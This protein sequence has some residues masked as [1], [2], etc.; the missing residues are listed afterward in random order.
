MK[1]S[2]SVRSW[3]VLG[4]L[5]L[6]LACENR[7][8]APPAP[9][10]LPSA[11]VSVA[12]EPPG[13]TLESLPIS[14]GP[15]DPGLFGFRRTDLPTVTTY[16]H[17]RAR[18]GRPPPAAFTI[19]WGY[20]KR[21]KPVAGGLLVD[22][23]GGVWN[24]TGVD[25]EREYQ[26]LGRVPSTEVVGMLA[27]AR[28][29]AKTTF[30]TSPGCRDC[31]GKS[32]RAY[33]IAGTEELTLA[34]EGLTEGYLKSPDADAVILW[35]LAIQERN[36]AR[37]ALGP[38]GL[39]L[40]IVSELRSLPITA[41]TPGPLLLELEHFHVGA[42]WGVAVDETGNVFRFNARGL[43]PREFRRI[44]KVARA[45][46]RRLVRLGQRAETSEWQDVRGNQISSQVR[47]DGALISDLS[48]FG[49]RRIG[50]EADELIAWIYAVY[51]QG[52]PVFETSWPKPSH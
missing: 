37:G 5:A 52:L 20:V 3:W 32:V 6:S 44:G 29:A 19:S 35:L 26:R 7:T 33:G 1:T 47:C 22:R 42:A 30:V 16:V 28:A 9:S 11:A 51:R 2:R 41:E 50:K 13:V 27:R 24:Y 43:A 15:S 4:S 18:T 49:K 38:Y 25:E 36:D 34:K 45:S 8:A 21:T 46:V 23:Q 10:S 17:E 39:E 12:L 31:G 40:P 48:E 14:V